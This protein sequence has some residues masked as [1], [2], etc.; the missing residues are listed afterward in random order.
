MYG[1][2][3]NKFERPFIRQRYYSNDKV[4]GLKYGYG[5]DRSVEVLGQPVEEEFGPEE[6]L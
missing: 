3:S 5:F 1:R 2:S 4:D 6:T